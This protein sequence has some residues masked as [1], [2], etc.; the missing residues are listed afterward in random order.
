LQNL[1]IRLTAS[2]WILAKFFA[3]TAYVKVFP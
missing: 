3:G 1:H 2:T